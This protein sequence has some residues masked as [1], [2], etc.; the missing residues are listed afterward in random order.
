M[1]IVVALTLTFCVAAAA[2]PPQ[3][4]DIPAGWPWHVVPHVVDGTLSGGTWTTSIIITNLG[5]TPAP[6]RINFYNNDGAP[7]AFSIVGRGTASTFNGNI[8][9]NGSTILTTVGST[10]SPLIQGWAQLD[11]SNSSD[12]VGLMAIF[13]QRVP[14]RADYEASVPASTPVDYNSVIPF[15][16]MPDSGQQYVSGF[17]ILNPQSAA[18][19][20]IP[21][22]FYDE[23]G[24]RLG[25]E[26]ILLGPRKK[27]VFVATDR[28]PVL[29]G[30][31]GTIKFALGSYGL[32]LL[33]FRF[34]PAAFTTLT[35]MDR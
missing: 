7:Q 27:L 32:S 29:A 26:T 31:R 15:D 30:K 8:P 6:Y 14:G 3:G 12:D 33:G 28:W 1:R 5:N 21:I 9:V 13:R 4:R 17:A 20:S 2:A 23:A 22:D 18:D 11:D 25:G 34:G 19:S 16:N 35:V 24:N 10:S